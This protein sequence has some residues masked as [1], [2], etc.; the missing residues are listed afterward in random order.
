M[1]AFHLALDRLFHQILVEVSL[2]VHL[3]LERIDL[4]T[5]VIEFVQLVE[6]VGICI[7]RFHIVVQFLVHLFELFLDAIESHRNVLDI[8]AHN[9]GNLLVAHV[10]EPEQDNGPVKGL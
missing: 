4:L 8:D 7:C 1:K 6:F 3:L 9:L 5:K 10:L 2:L